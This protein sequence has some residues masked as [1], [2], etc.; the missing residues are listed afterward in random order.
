MKTKLL[1]AKVRRKWIAPFFLK[2]FLLLFC[3]NSYAL[4]NNIAFQ[5]A[6]IKIE[7]DQSMTVEE[8]FDLIQQQ[9]DYSFIFPANAFAKA[10]KVTVKKGEILLKDLL[11]KSLD[12]TG[13]T[14]EIIEKRAILL[15][16]KS[17]GTPASK[18]EVLQ[19]VSGTVTD[20][21]AMPLPGVNVYVE[22][23]T[24]GTQTDFDGNYSL[25][26]R[27][28]DV[29]V[30]QF[31]G[32]T[33][34]KVTVGDKEVLNVVLKEELEGL[35]EVV[36]VG[37]GTQ[38]KS[39]V[40]GA[41]STVKSEDL[42][43]VVSTN[44][45]DGMQGRVSGVNVTNSSGSPGAAPEISIRGFGTF[46]NNE[47]LYIVDG[48][49]ADPYFIDS[50][51]IES[52]EILKDAAS[53]AIYGTRAANGVVI[54]TTK[55][56]TKGLPQVDVESSYSLNSP[57][58][59]MNL[60]NA[61]EYVEVHR[62]MY[63]NA[64]M[65]LP[66]Y[67]QNPPN[68]DTDW[69]DQTHRDGYLLNN[70]VRV[71]GGAENITYSI[72]GNMAEE[73]GVLLGSQFTKKGISSNL[74]LSK[75]KLK[76]STSLNY[77]ETYKED[78]KFS[79]RETYFISPLIPVLD[80]NKESGFG[81]RTGDTP[82]HRNP[83]GEDNFIDGHTRLKYF[84][85][86][87]NISYEVIDGLTAR[88]G[89]SLSNLQDYTYEFH[90]PF[91]VRDV[92][93]IAQREF[94]FISEYNSTSRRLNQEYTLNYKFDL[95]QHSFDLLAGYQ[96]IEEPLKWTY[97]QA[98]GYKT[99]ENGNKIPAII[100]DPSFNT[101]DAFSDGT[102]SASGTNA[103][104]AL[105]SQ[106]GRLNYSFMDRYLLQASLRRDGSS[107]FGENNKY[108]Y[109][110]SFALGWKVTDE[111]FM[112]EQ[113]IF[114][115]LK[116]RY[117]WGQAGN[118][119]ALGYY[120]YIPLISQGKSYYNGG[121][122]FGMPQTSYIGS[123]ARDLENPDLKWE[124]N[125]SSNFGLDF[126][127]LQNKL[128]GSVNYYKS[129]TEDLLIIKEVPPSAGVNNPVV[130]VGEFENKGFEFEM[131]YRNNDHAVNYSAAAT[132]TT[133][134]SEVTS[135]SN[136]D[137]V[138][139]G[140]GLLFGSDHFVNQTKVGFEPGA[141]FLP[142]AAGIFQSEAEVAAHSVNGNPIQPNAA[143]GDIRFV[144]QNNDGVIN[145]QDE[146]Y[147]GTAIPKYEY[148]LNLSADYA[149]FDFTVFFQG[150]GGNKIYNGNDFRLLSMDTGRNFRAESLNAWTPTNTNTDIPRAVLNDP[151]RNNRA[152]TRFLED[153][154]Y[155]RVKT[156]QLGYSIPEA[157]L[158]NLFIDNLRLFVTAQNYFTFTNYSGLD[159]EV[160]GAILSRGIDSNLYPKYKSLIGG[161]QLKF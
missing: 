92:Q 140:I 22:G 3:I 74:N 103:T 154:D 130:N 52:I 5:A 15:K 123:I 97:A 16:E 58:E 8:T 9:T 91:R 79:I 112:Q 34:Q 48:V 128:T 38:K 125:T 77:N 89:Y 105:A 61:S 141:F 2:L 80:E 51:N 135:L 151:N 17:T 87:A 159:P 73:E 132:F 56:G 109:F 55:K 53:G 127:A 65:Q 153:G 67:V 137:Q 117:S 110:P 27:P 101:L 25:E 142:V 33:T 116:L 145:E 94:A 96:R 98:E 72:A 82:D 36:V 161:I 14:Y 102:Y 143:P 11:Q 95:N 156:I 148:S 6:K 59:E 40:T 7:Q 20:E 50:N 30:F 129:I 68:V 104:Y 19:T 124:T 113:E 150:A 37:Y 106:F 46:G 81:Y 75:G 70:N 13:Y 147:A 24:T 42:N 83:I 44:P 69:I 35:D 111:A 120:D 144:D 21:K 108:G 10:P 155:L 1:D 133:I 78:Y 90:Q 122:V 49:Q 43:K 66:E 86:S 118:D 88:A 138:L 18:K 23:T 31:L 39:D 126:R 146:V 62:Q 119:S 157:R 152:S 64:G 149:G 28:Q 60:L 76:V 47:P 121:Y 134:N 131:L 54:I 45:L 41:I 100:L 136:D 12:K 32:F 63:E 57:R 71:S 139:Y 4:E 85:G 160:G 84:L 115:F 93:D 158:E 26:V 114:D 29:L 107:K 99:D